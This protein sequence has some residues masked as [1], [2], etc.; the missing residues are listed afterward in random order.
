VTAGDVNALQTA[1]LVGV[2]YG[3]ALAGKDPGH[4][5]LGITLGATYVAGALVADAAISRPFDLTTAEANISTIG[6]IAGGLI[7]LAVPVLAQSSE[8]SLVFGSA[9]VGATLGLSAALA[10]AKPL[11]AAR[12]RLS[13]SDSRRARLQAQAVTPWVGGLLARRPGAYP[14]VRLT[15]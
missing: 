4:R 13:T 10:I 9:A 15:F 2:L 1:A 8:N 7:G 11:P 6:A 5:T 12:A 14:F 3:A